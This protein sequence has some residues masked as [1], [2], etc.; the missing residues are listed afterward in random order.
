MADAKTPKPKRKW[1]PRAPS[2]EVPRCTVCGGHERPDCDP[3]AKPR[4]EQFPGA[5][6]L[7][8]AIEARL[9]RFEKRL[10]AMAD[11]LAPALYAW[12]NIRSRIPGWILSLGDPP[13]PA[14]QR[15]PVRRGTRDE[16]PD[17]G[18]E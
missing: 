11:A 8:H 13:A 12:R 5:T 9:D 6:H 10:D 4:P 17:D 1:K 7:A 15:P 14:P 18:E 16:M 2:A 3:N